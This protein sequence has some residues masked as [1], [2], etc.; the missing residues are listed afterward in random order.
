MYLFK[1]TTWSGCTLCNKIYNCCFGVPWGYYLWDKWRSY[2]YR[3]S[4][5]P[6]W[7]RTGQLKNTS[8]SIKNFS[9]FRI[10]SNFS[11]WSITCNLSLLDIHCWQTIYDL[12]TLSSNH[13]LDHNPQFIEISGRPT[14]CQS[15][16]RYPNI[17]ANF[18][19]EMSVER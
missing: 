5:C 4:F 17:F 3:W 9:N 18:A 2:L 7:F 12:L 6:L 1:Q 11:L 13:I 10:E 14:L 15:N 8:L 16:W 19:K